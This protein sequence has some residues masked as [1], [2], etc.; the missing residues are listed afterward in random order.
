MGD[1]IVGE[2]LRRFSL[3][4]KCCYYDCKAANCGMKE[5]MTDVCLKGDSMSSDCH[6]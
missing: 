6:Y 2:C 3:T 5:A 4:D 1:F